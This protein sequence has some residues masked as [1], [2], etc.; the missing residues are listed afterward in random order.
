MAA[1][2]SFSSFLYA[3]GGVANLVAVRGLQLSSKRGLQ[4]PGPAGAGGLGARGA[5][6]DR[7][8]DSH[9]NHTIDS[10][11]IQKVRMKMC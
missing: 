9:N 5:W 1:A 8:K 7:L 4:D 2:S 3:S 11:N 10:N 6:K